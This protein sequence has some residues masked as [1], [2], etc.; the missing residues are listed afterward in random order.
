E[1]NNNKGKKQSY[2][3]TY[4][5]DDDDSSSSCD[6]SDSVS[7]LDKDSTAFNVCE[8]INGYDSDETIEKSS[9]QNALINFFGMLGLLLGQTKDYKKNNM[10][11]ESGIAEITP[12][13]IPV[14]KKHKSA[15]RAL[16]YETV[17]CLIEVE[18][19]EFIV[20]PDVDHRKYKVGYKKIKDDSEADK[21]NKHR[22]NRNTRY[23][24]ANYLISAFD[25]AIENFDPDDIDFLM[26][27]KDI[28][29]GDKSCTDIEAD[30]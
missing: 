12:K 18:D 24:T 19:V 14:N 11:L 9:V 30:E 21:Y 26:S 2:I 20:N 16:V 13:Y 3:E 1:M 15:F 28:H 7:E 29:S 22:V 27:N 4:I 5:T 8:D 6:S 17:E 23:A 10:N 25:P